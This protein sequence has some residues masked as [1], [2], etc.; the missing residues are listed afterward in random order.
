MAG[1]RRDKYGDDNDGDDGEMSVLM[2]MR[3][4]SLVKLVIG[5]DAAGLDGLDGLNGLN[6]LNGLDDLDGRMVG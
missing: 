5:E 6:G 3:M 2:W 1:I 4:A